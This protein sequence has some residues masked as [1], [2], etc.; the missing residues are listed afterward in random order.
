MRKQFSEIFSIHSFQANNLFTKHNR[1]FPSGVNCLLYPLADKMKHPDS[2]CIASEIS[3]LTSFRYA[4]RLHLPV[5]Q[6]IK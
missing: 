1:E 6:K 5:S 2:C 4:N 3:G